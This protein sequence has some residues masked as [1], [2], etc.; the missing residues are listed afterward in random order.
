M[1]IVLD[2]QATGSD[3]CYSC[4]Q[5]ASLATLPIRERILVGAGWRAAH[6]IRCALPGWLVLVA[7]R[8]ITTIADLDAAAAAELGVLCRTLSLALT[9]VTGC[10]K[11]YVAAFSEAPG[12][13]HLHVHVIPRAHDVPVEERGPSIFRYLREPSAAWVPEAAMNDL[14][15]ALAARITTTA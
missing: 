5:E 10:A 11:T 2:D 15:R 4:K 12:F 7:R 9:D 1:T 3:S 6:A 13:D 8:H 14:A